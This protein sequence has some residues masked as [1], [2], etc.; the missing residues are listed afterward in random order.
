MSVQGVRTSEILSANV[1]AFSALGASSPPWDLESLRSRCEEI[2]TLQGNRGREYQELLGHIHE[3]IQDRLAPGNYD[4]L[5]RNLLLISQIMPIDIKERESTKEVLG[6]IFFS[7]TDLAP[8]CLLK[9]FC[10]IVNDAIGTRTAIYREILDLLESSLQRGVTFGALE[11][12]GQCFTLVA[13]EIPSDIK[14]KAGVKSMISSIDKHVASL[15]KNYCL[16]INRGERGNPIAAYRDILN[17]TEE[18]AQLPETIE[19]L[20]RLGHNLL[21]TIRMMPSGIRQ[22]SEIELSTDGIKQRLIGLYR[23]IFVP[24]REHILEARRSS[25]VLVFQRRIQVIS[26]H[27]PNGLDPT[28]A[29]EVQKYLSF[30]NRKYLTRSFVEH[31]HGVA[32]SQDGLTSSALVGPTRLQERNIY[33]IL[34]IDGGGIRGIIPAT[35][36]VA[37]ERFTHEPIANLFQLIG[38]TS[39]GGILALGLTK[40]HND[41]SGR[42]EYSAQNLLNLYTQQHD[43]IFRPNLSY[44]EDTS[45]LKVGEKINEAIHNPRYRTPNLFQETFGRLGLSSALTDIVI[46]ANTQEAIISKVCSVSMSAITGV[47]SLFSGAFGYKPT[48]IWS[49]DGL[50][51]EVHLFTN[52][53]LKSLSYSLND[54]ERR[55]EFSRR[56]SDP[57]RSTELVREYSIYPESTGDFLMADIA[58]VTSAA[59]SYFP[60]VSYN[61]KLFID[62]GV[63]QNNPAIPC[64]LEALNRGKKKDSL[65]MVSLGTGVA[66]RHSPRADLGSSLTSLWFQTTQPHL[67]EDLALMDMLDSGASYRFQHHFKDHVPDLDDTCFETIEMLQEKGNELVEDNIDHIREVCRVL[68][69]ESI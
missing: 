16:S 44:R 54:I 5:S 3:A 35:M 27:L 26:S 66:P 51:K 30:S 6:K 20:H 28:L 1:R 39:T 62:G 59:P 19:E 61:D 40:P 10:S 9:S 50:P 53:G 58:K 11:R 13:H 14:K 45:E 2:N 32:T 25:N 55:Y 24:L 49:H 12:I 34:S 56:Y 21:L 52:S 42:P 31:R 17:S 22:T 65:F 46:T 8:L 29:E 15:L 43:Q 60:P 47:V 68:R 69:P 64:V 4:F 67:Q 63:L 36:L 48:P 23:S 18:S 33:P 7:Q 37:I 57:T 38:G 41:G